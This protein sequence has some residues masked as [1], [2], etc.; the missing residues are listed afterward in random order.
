MRIFQNVRST[1]DYVPSI[2]VNV[3]TVYIRSDIKRVEEMEFSGWEYNEIQYDK[4]EYIEKL[5]NE[6]DAGM[7]ALIISLLMA[8]IDML[9]A[10]VSQLEEVK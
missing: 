9:N 5:A 1:A 4:N 7:L 8:E 6:D 10:R 2:E 3:D